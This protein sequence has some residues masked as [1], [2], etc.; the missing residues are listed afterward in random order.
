MDFSKKI[1]SLI[2][3]PEG[4]NLEYKSVMLPSRAMAQ[5]IAGFANAEGGYVIFGISDK[6][7][8]PEIQGLSQDFQ[9]NAILHKA[10]DLLSPKPNVQYQYVNIDGKTVYGI[11]VEKSST[12]VL[13][14]N[15]LYQRKNDSLVLVNPPD[16]QF[17]RAGYSRLKEIY[18]RM[19]GQKKGSTNARNRQIEHYQSIL[20]ISDDLE[21]LLYP[22][23]P[24][25]PTTNSEG[26]I[27]SRILFS[28][29][30]DNFEMYLSDL[31][32]EIFLANPATLKS[33]QTVTIEEVLNCADLQEFVRYWA[34]EKIGKLQRG[35]VKG[36]IK[37]NRQISGLSVLDEP[38]QNE[39]ERILQIRHL[40]AHRNGVVDE[41]FLQFFPG[42]F[43]LSTE[44]QL[45]MENIC[46]KLEYLVG[47]SEKI[48]RAA[49][50]KFQLE[51]VQ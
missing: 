15:K 8:P 42:Q 32:Y 5:L 39:L 6:H 50:T 33:S 47:V 18:Q 41:K 40:Y 43:T 17:S 24:H 36:F 22:V 12:T 1:Q 13:L 16:M 11:G 37:D 10:M 49:I 4:P 3:Q 23:S 48:D 7:G 2:G 25:S 45:S 14:E 51:T 34:K 38:T 29:A 44:H 26:K 19:E 9:A 27:L 30:V 35:S 28:S 46:D 21:R 20:K 31:L